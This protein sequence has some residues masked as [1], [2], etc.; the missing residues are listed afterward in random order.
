MSRETEA[1]IAEGKARAAARWA[2]LTPAEIER[3]AAMERRARW[4]FRHAHIAGDT[5]GKGR[6][7][8][9]ICEEGCTV[10]HLA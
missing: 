9:R 6:A 4:V 10:N 7:P 3:V 8:V 1:Q 5:P 2:E